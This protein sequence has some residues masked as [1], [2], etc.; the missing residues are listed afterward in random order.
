MKLVYQTINI[1]VIIVQQVVLA[2]NINTNITLLTIQN[3]ILNKTI[4]CPAVSGF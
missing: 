3:D 2:L 4:K 1:I